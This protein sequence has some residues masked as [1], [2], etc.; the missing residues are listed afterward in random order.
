MVDNK[1]DEYFKEWKDREA[2]AEAMLPLI[3]KLYRD[4]EV[5]CTVFDRSL[6]QKSIIDILRAHRFARQ[7]ID[8]EIWLKIPIRCC[9]P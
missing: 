5:V 1:T 8:R 4:H 6:A 2:I 3:G 7:I 9:R